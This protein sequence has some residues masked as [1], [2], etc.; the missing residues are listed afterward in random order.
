M[1]AC[2]CVLLGV[3]VYIDICLYVAVRVQ[4][5]QSRSV[6]SMESVSEY[7]TEYELLKRGFRIT[8][9]NNNISSEI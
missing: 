2:V 5:C 9:T 1:F 3:Y 7:Y 6:K 4:L 8:H